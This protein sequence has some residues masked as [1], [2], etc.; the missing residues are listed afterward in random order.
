MT[1]FEMAAT[2]ASVDAALILEGV[3]EATRKRVLDRLGKTLATVA[4]APPRNVVDLRA[5]RVT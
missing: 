5:Q 3:D 4:T 2:I 1:L